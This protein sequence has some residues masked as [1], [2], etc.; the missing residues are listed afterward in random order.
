MT[1]T[2]VRQAV[3]PPETPTA[4]RVASLRDDV[5]GVILGA[6]L[7]GGVLI[8]A[9]AHTNVLSSDSGFFTPWHAM[10]YTGFAGSAAWTWWLAFRHRSENA[11]WWRN[12]WP[13]G[14]GIGAIATLLFFVGGAMDMLWHSI[15]GVEVSIRA[16]LS[17][18]H[19][20]ISVAGTLLV[21]NQLRSWWASG[22]GGWRTVTGLTSIS[23]GTT[24]AMTVLVGMTSLNTIAPTLAFAPVRGVASTQTAAAQGIQSYLIGTAFLLIPFLLVQRR[25][26][27]PGTATAIALGVGLFQLI[28]REF[29][30]P[31]TAAILGMILGALL[32][33]LALWRLDLLR[34][35]T[36]PGRLPIAAGIFAAA[37]WSGHLLGLHFAAGIHWPAELWAGIV[38][39]TA[40]LGALMGLLAASPR[41]QPQP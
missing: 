28:Q 12:S 24:F 1:S 23:L 13:A 27:V 22:E 29:P 38:V 11:L 41:T 26:R 37:L 40:I 35:P 8:D 5:I 18:S 34:G 32:A 39:V 19:L 15:F 20:L 17:P 3:K 10:L 30:L 33:D 4:P 36:A 14:Y 2:Q 31:A 25:R 21:T 9:W 16:A 7:V 6:A